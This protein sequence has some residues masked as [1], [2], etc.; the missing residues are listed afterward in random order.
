MTHPV[1]SVYVT[2]TSTVP[3]LGRRRQYRRLSHTLRALT[4]T[5]AVAACGVGRETTPMLPIHEMSIR[6]LQESMALGEITCALA[7]AHFCARIEAFS[8]QGPR[9]NAVL[10]VNPDAASL[11]A[12]S[13]RER[14]AGHVRGV[15]WWW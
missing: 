5:A 9:L 11:A 7:T 8:A 1:L 6:E 14:A 3:E 12:A 2:V 13:D 4:D 10:E 15:W